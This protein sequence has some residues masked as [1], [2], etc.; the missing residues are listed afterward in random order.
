MFTYAYT[1]S[2][3]GTY[4]QQASHIT[5]TMLHHRAKALGLLAEAQEKLGRSDEAR[6][7]LST[8]LG[9]LESPLAYSA[10]AASQPLAL[11]DGYDTFSFHEEL[12]ARQHKRV[13]DGEVSC[14]GLCRDGWSQRS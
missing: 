2:M 9:L 6:Q 10:E 3:K 5:V 13:K 7:T 12:L 4:A 11:G 14:E 8:A 1:L